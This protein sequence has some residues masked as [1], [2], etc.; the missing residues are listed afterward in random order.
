MDV[1][2]SID[3]GNGNVS[4]LETRI[5]FGYENLIPFSLKS[6]RVASILDGYVPVSFDFLRLAVGYGKSTVMVVT[7]GSGSLKEISFSSNFGTGIRSGS[8]LDVASQIRDIVP[9]MAL[10]FGIVLRSSERS[11]PVFLAEVVMCAMDSVQGGIDS[12]ILTAIVLV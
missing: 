3:G 12:S 4:S 2:I 11:S 8:L 10:R 9:D 6:L 1:P 5:P 7:A